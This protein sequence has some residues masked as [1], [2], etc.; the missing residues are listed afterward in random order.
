MTHQ[1]SPSDIFPWNENFETGILVI[2]EQHRKLVELLNKLASHLAYEA[3]KPELNQVFDEMAEYTLI[4][5]ETEE[6]IWR[7]YLPADDF[8]LEHEKSHSDF[9]QEL[10]LL[11]GKQNSLATEQ[12]ID[13]IVIFLTHW[14][15]FHILESDKNMAKIVLAMQQ[16]MTLSEAKEKAH[17][18][19]SGAL[20]ILI[21]T[22]LS[23][24]DTLS[25]RTLQLMREIAERQRAEDRL[26]LSRRVIDSTLEAIFITDAG[27]RI[28][29]T[30]P[31]FCQDVRQEHE[32]LVGKDIRRIKPD[33]FS[34]SKTDIIWRTATESGHWAGETVGR[35]ANGEIEG[36][37]LVLSSIKDHQGAITHYVGVV[38]AITQLVKR[39]QILEVEA[40]HDALTGL[41]N[42]RLLQDRLEQAIQ[43]SK[44]GGH[45]LAVCY[46]DLDGFKLVNDTLGHDAGDD[47][48]RVIAGRLSKVL[49]G[50]DTVVRSGGDEFVL[51]LGDLDSEQDATQLLNRLLL[52][53]AQPILIHGMPVNVSA[54]IGVTLYPP[55][56]GTAGQLLKHADEAMFAAKKEGKSRYYFF[57]VL[58]TRAQEA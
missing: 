54:S 19:M 41:P 17:I 53:I 39:Q 5:F 31:A 42:R 15:A 44:R 12:V 13:E 43:R 7:K 3:D 29:D 28:I 55:D 40:N 6:G 2:D 22:V 49:R 52:D 46:L 14:L 23:M 33:L 16:G 10:I 45:V 32:Q 38:S 56:S 51:L 35:D 26:R 58:N 20:R 36:A 4:H 50:V 34:H 8:S 1:L 30:N 37:W 21:E 24:Y 57:P 11:R 9:V 27:G 48:L 47:V 18:E 25:S